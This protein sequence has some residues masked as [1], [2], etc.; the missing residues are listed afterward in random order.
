MQRLRSHYQAELKL[1]LLS[2]LIIYKKYELNPRDARSQINERV[3]FLQIKIPS[4]KLLQA[5]SYCTL[6][7]IL[8]NFPY[9]Q[10]DLAIIR[11]ELFQRE[12]KLCS[13][14]DLTL[15]N[16]INLFSFLPPLFLAAY[17][18][19]QQYGKDEV[20]GLRRSKTTSYALFSFPISL[21]VNQRC[22]FQGKKNICMHL[23]IFLVL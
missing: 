13:T 14:I 10:G 20:Q 17:L 16:T 6:Y 18:C 5:S 7:C 3:I 19:H 1:P 23:L 4:S 2:V 22:A 9:G 8:R 21:T 15:N 11:C 12:L